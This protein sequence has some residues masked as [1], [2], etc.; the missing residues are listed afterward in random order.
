MFQEKGASETSTYALRY[1]R[2]LLLKK[3][4]KENHP[5]MRVENQLIGEAAEA[6]K[7]SGLVAGEAVTMVRTAA[8]RRI[9]M[10]PEGTEV[11]SELIKAVNSDCFHDIAGK[12]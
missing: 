9:L 4:C 5:V 11:Q 1:V 8:I 10:L 6:V 12:R 2:R 3:L 7:K